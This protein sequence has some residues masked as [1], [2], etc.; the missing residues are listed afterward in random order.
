M[1][2]PDTR[3][4]PDLAGR[5]IVLTGAMGVLASEMAA[6]LACCGANLAL[7][8]RRTDRADAVRQRVGHD[9]ASRTLVVACDVLDRASLEQ[10]L[11]A[12]VERFQRVDGLVNAAGGNAPDATTSGDRSFFD[13]PL[14]ALRQVTDLNLLGTVLPSQV[15]GR[16]MAAQGD[17]VIL[18]VTS[19][20][21]DR[22]LTRIPAYSAAKAGVSNF[23][24]W[25]AVHIAQEY[26]PRIRV[27]AIAPGFFLTRQ[28]AF[29]LQ[30][31]SG[32]PTPRG[33]AILAH[34]PMRRFGT[35]ADLLGA[36]VWLLSPAASFVTGAVI[37]ID[38]G[39][40]AFSG[41]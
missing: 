14:E 8:D 2:S 6:A 26:S 29:L 22:P 32:E 40:G 17:G 5:T 15:F 16:Q 24:Q 25:L 34:T 7:L 39:F 18:N 9:A 12:I 11:A 23:T 30:D 33:L 35:P 21:A 10:A 3:F 27:N 31:E 13:L 4:L 19:M 1:S 37:P 36:V 28:N 38:G 20:S 41:V